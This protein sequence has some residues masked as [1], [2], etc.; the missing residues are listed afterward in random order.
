MKNGSRIR[1]STLVLAAVIGI[2]LA[3]RGEAFGKKSE[4]FAPSGQWEPYFMD[5]KGKMTPF[6]QPPER[7]SDKDWK[8]LRFTDYSGPKIRVAVMQVEN[9]TA[10]AAAANG[11]GAVVVT[12]KA[13]EVNV[14]SIEELLASA[15]SS[16]HRFEIVDRKDIE[17]TLQEQDLGASGRTTRDTAAKTGQ[18][19][20]AE[21]L[22]YAAV[23]E[24]TPV[25]SSTGGT[26]NKAANPLGLG[27]SR[28]VSEVALSV[29]VVN[30]GS[31]ANFL[32]TTKRA[33]AETW[34]VNLTGVN[35]GSGSGGVKT[36]QDAP[37]GYAVEA[38]INKAVYDLVSKLKDRPWSGSVIRMAG[39]Q[40][41]VDAGS[42]SG[43][44]S[45]AELVVKSLGA[46]I[47]GL[48]GESLGKE[49]VT[50]GTLRVVD[51]QERYSVAEI[52]EGCKGLKVGDRV[53]FRISS[54]KVLSSAFNR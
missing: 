45:G 38:C 33:T 44:T 41:F 24:Y 25:K 9:R 21:Y 12:D 27:V 14:A 18:I 26:V 19:V 4:A 43:L 16:T 42:A 10:T 29:R 7:N 49:T 47:Q 13:A 5:S 31:S 39:Q 46:D 40:V 32:N 36:I 17:K 22:V 2:T 15:I 53:E 28:T 48:N 50:I 1:R 3:V 54:P 8:F 30:A 11:S 23:N 6:L 52:V 35:A 51:V 37:I 20:G 34:N